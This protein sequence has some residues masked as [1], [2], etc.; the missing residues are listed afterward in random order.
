MTD[1]LCDQHRTKDWRLK[2]SP[3]LKPLIVLLEIRTQETEQL[4]VTLC[5]VTRVM[6]EF[7]DWCELG[8]R[9]SQ[10]GG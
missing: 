2:E 4:N 6:L 3:V 8:E 1:E 9:E 10:E 7:R 5:G